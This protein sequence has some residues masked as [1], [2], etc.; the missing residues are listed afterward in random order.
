M[1]YY[2]NFFRYGG[3][4]LDALNLFCSLSESCGG[5][6]VA[7]YHDDVWRSFDKVVFYFGKCPTDALSDC[8]PG[9]FSLV[10]LFAAQV[11]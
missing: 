4:I 11:G 5:I 8:F 6:F 7:L 10:S 3:Q 2:L 9:S 1:K